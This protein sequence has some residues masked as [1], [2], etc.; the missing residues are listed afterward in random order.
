MSF[1]V[2]YELIDFPKIQVIYKGLEKRVSKPDPYTNHTVVKIL[3]LEN[4]TINSNRYDL[5]LQHAN[6]DIIITLFRNH[7]RKYYYILKQAHVQ[8]CYITSSTL[9]ISKCK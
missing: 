3:I 8:T 5:E 6:D 2:S 9:N 1:D 7:R 4:R